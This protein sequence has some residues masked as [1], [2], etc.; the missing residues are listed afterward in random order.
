M[1][2]TLCE[3][4]TLQVLRQDPALQNLMERLPPSVQGYL[5]G[6]LRVRP[7]FRGCPLRVGSRYRL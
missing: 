6:H 4:E 3:Q 2:K 7:R 5:R 1:S